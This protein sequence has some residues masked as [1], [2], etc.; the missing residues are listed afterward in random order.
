M[1]IGIDLSYQIWKILLEGRLSQYFVEKGS[2]V[3]F[4]NMPETKVTAGVFYKELLFSSNLDLKTGFVAYYTGKQNLRY[5]PIPHWGTLYND[6]DS[7]LTVDFTISAEI[8]KA[9]IVYFNWE[10]LF[11]KQYYITPYYPMLGRN[12]RFG[13][14]WEIFN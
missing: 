13:V 4:I 6:V 5:L 14:A 9:A 3:E 1:G 10:N 8:Q 11:D 2:S 12:I 7:W